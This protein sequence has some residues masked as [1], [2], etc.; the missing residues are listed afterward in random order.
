MRWIHP[1][2]GAVGGNW[3]LG[4]VTHL[5]WP[6]SIPGRSARAA[7]PVGAVGRLLGR[8]Q[9]L[10]AVDRQYQV[11]AH[12][13]LSHGPAVGHTGQESRIT[14]AL[15]DTHRTRDLVGVA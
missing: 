1:R 5:K 2:V 3:G 8:R 7:A 4:T 13:N 10:G 11:R 15:F 12:Q 9:L 14:P 6:A